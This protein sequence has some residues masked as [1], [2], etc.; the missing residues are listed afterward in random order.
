[1]YDWIHIQGA[2]V[3]FSRRTYDTTE[4]ARA[5]LQVHLD[6][7]YPEAAA[8]LRA[9][10]VY[11]GQPSVS[12]PGGHTWRVQEAGKSVTLMVGD[13]PRTF[14]RPA[15][16]PAPQ[17]ED[18]GGARLLVDQAVR[19]RQWRSSG[20]SLAAALCLP[21][22]LFVVGLL[23]FANS[24]P[25]NDR[26]APNCDGK[27][28]S[29]GSVCIT[30]KGSDRTDEGYEEIRARRKMDKPENRAAGGVIMALGLLLAVPGVVK[31]SPSRPWG[32][33]A[34][35]ACP[36]CGKRELREK[37]AAAEKKT[38]RDTVMRYGAVVT[39]CT[40]ECGYTAARTP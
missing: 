21:V 35:G 29:P 22:L 20:K 25:S 28:M 15:P 4:E 32:K 39:L 8:R 31:L 11:P 2:T 23:F 6:A 27:A 10:P 12:L 38:G 9:L 37:S 17:R 33:P 16:K 19:E 7:R 14:R 1:M 36:R 40:P 26:S 5:A 30:W 24:G 13:E 18:P 34:S 3:Q